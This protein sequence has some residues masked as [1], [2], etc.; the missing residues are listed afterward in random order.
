MRLYLLRWNPTISS[1]TAPRFR[2]RLRKLARRPECHGL[3]MNWSIYEPDLLQPGDWFVFCRVGTDADGIAGLGRFTSRPYLDTSWR[4]DGRII[5][6][7]DMLTLMLQEPNATGLWSAD[8][9]ADDFP[10]I[11]WHTGHAGVPVSADTAER[12]AI[13]LVRDLATLPD[14]PLPG[15]AIRQGDGGRF[16]LACALLSELCP[17]LLARVKATQTAT[18]SLTEPRLPNYGDELIVDLE[19]LRD[20]ANLL[21]CVRLLAWPTAV[22]PDDDFDIQRHLPPP[23]QSE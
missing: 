23:D 1:Y 2:Q 13:R 15:L 14:V 21:A 7:A 16:S 9:L 22:S 12:L 18:D 8:S 5:L 3:T 17:K 10:D 19:R 6:Y 11:T 4:R 20:D